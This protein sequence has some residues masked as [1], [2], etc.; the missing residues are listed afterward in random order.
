MKTINVIQAGCGAVGKALAA[1]VAERNFFLRERLGFELK[2]QGIFSSQKYIF[3]DQG[4][5][6]K[7]ADGIVSAL[8]KGATYQGWEELKQKVR[9][10]TIVV[11]VTA[12]PTAGMHQTVLRA[13]GIIVT[14]NKKPLTEK[15]EIYRE[16]HA[17]TGRYFYETTVGSSTPAI[18]TLQDL[19]RTGDEVMEIKAV[20]SGTLGFVCS[21]L[22]REGVKFSE[23]VRKAKEKGYTEP[24]PRDDLSGVDVARK[25]LI[26]GREIGLSAEMDDIRLEGMVPRELASI[27]GVEVFLE[28]LKILDKEY[29]ERMD[30]WR[31]RGEAPQFVAGI[32]PDGVAVGLVG[33]RLGEPLGRL[34]GPENFLSFKTRIF[35]E[36]PLILQGKGAG[37]QYTAEGVL[38][39][40]IRAGYNI[41]I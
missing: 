10:G 16:L 25:A 4:L 36:T 2:L 26:L 15:M 23:I 9:P 32:T 22:R 34:A 7:S 3:A 5:D 12:A 17:D 28:K 38:Q 19:I 33:V 29:E 39:D 21:E 40:I 11:D 6:F 37:V 13:G 18:Q 8:D 27:D 14:A 35:N 20:L 1:L 41:L 31:A 30:E 24:H